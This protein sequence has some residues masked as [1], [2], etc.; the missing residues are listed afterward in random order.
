MKK[1][2]LQGF[3]W[4]SIY[5]LITLAPL[6]TL[7]A[8]PR[9]AGREL[10]R[11]LSVGLGFC[12][13]AMVGLQFVLTAR[14]KVIK[15][16]YGSDIV[17]FFHRQ[18]SLVTFA[19]I[20]AHPLMLFIFDPQYL[21]LLNLATAPWAARFGVA[22][23]ILFMALISLSIWRK[24]IRFEYDQWRIWHGILAIAALTLA[25][26][27]IEL[28]GYYLNTL[29]KQLFWG[30]YGA[31]WVGVL[32]WVRV[33]KPFLLLRKPYLV[34]DVISERGNTWTIILR[35]VNHDGFRF[36]PGQFSWITAWNSP[37]QDH[38]HPFS[39]SSS[40]EQ[41]S[42]LA[43]TIKEL[44]DFT[45]RIKDLTR[46]QRI[47]VD[48]PFGSFSI[49]RHPNS[50]EFVFIAGGIG[51][52]PMMSMLRTLADRRDLRPLTLVYANKN[53]ETATFLEE[54]DELPQRLNIKIVHVLESPPEG[55]NGEKGFVTTEM[56]KRI[57]PEK[58]DLNAM[59]VFNCGPGPMMDA[60]EK[61]LIQLGVPMGD[62]HS[63]RFDLV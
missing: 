29:W 12:G 20:A 17:Y 53:L 14:F 7:M 62:F 9:P 38:E 23:I 50:K 5:I 19:L 36:Q 57:L 55:W 31:L 24:K 56:L 40:A 15:S 63:E 54:I 42:Q 28:R 43:F 41:T 2:F 58:R 16:P 60:V 52:T 32:A 59:E 25:L 33:I 13:F 18:I 27:H 3:F 61:A 48:G 1:R 37:F 51:I 21:N 26:V 45:R 8:G 34:E 10:W 30:I 11:D 44:G 46:G 39:I 47:Y 6:L 4:I 49:D 35:P 22:A